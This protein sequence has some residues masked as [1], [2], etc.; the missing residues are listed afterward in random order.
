MFDKVISSPYT[1]PALISGAMQV[2]GA[3][4]AGYGQKQ[5]Q[6]DQQEYERRMMQEQIDRRNANVGAELFVPGQYATAPGPAPMPAGLARKYMP[7]DY[8]DPSGVYSRLPP[9]VLPGQYVMS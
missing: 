8:R 6:E 3:V 1:A 7:K 9:G 4:I 5:A 2:G